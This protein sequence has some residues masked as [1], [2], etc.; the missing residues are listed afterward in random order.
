MIEVENLFKRYGPVMAVN[1]V[2]FTIEP[3]EIVGLL[4]PNGAGKSTTIRVMSTFL[5]PNAGRVRIDGHDVMENPLAVRQVLG[6]LPEN[7]PLYEEM[8]V[9]D[10]VRFILSARGVPRSERQARTEETVDRCGIRSVLKK[11][12]GELSK[13][14]R[15]RVGLAQAMIH[16]PAFLILDEPSSGLDP[17]QIVE[18]RKLIKEISTEKT[19]ILSTHIL[20]EVEA[21][22]D[23]VLIMHDG[24]I[25]V[26]AKLR[27]L[28]EGGGG[29]AVYEMRIEGASAEDV[30]Q[31]TAVL[32]E[33]QSVTAGADG[34]FEVRAD[35][36]KDLGGTLFDLA[37]AS[38]WRIL[39]LSRRRETLESIFQRLTSDA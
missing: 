15:Q 6:Y 12:I 21:T 19:I 33:V 27:D 39:E 38:G 4:G 29:G 34:H 2:S 23:R 9:S 13:G 31:K 17:N 7:A 8:K 32:P 24:R 10:Y 37:V 22:C 28:Q 3:G 35:D 1:N 5:A 11:S 30:R 18:I 25:V 20:A 26:D 14:F 36:G 16:N